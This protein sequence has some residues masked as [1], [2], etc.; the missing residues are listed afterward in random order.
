MANEA[1]RLQRQKASA[2]Y[3]KMRNEYR[4]NLADLEIVINDEDYADKTT[5]LLNGPRLRNGLQ[6]YIP[7]WTNT[8][9]LGGPLTKSNCFWILGRGR[10][11][12]RWVSTSSRQRRM[13]LFRRPSLMK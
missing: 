13:G 11:G 12:C 3:L 5:G 8:A 1:S 4:A 10:G 7:P 2:D 6:V 9:P